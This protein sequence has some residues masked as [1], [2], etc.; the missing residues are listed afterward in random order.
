MDARA[1]FDSEVPLPHS[2]LIS[3]FDTPVYATNYSLK[4]S[5]NI[6]YRIEGKVGILVAV[7]VLVCVVTVVVVSLQEPRNVYNQNR[8]NQQELHEVKFGLDSPP[9]FKEIGIV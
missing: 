6:I 3:N 5:R 2:L 1:L 4:I 9:S 8:V 7:V